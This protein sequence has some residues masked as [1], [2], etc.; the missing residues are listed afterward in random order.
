MLEEAAVSKEGEVPVHTSERRQVMREHSPGAACSKGVKHGVEQFTFGVK[1][2]TAGWLD[3]R[4]ERFDFSPLLIGQVCRI[5]PSLSGFV[6][7]I[8]YLNYYFLDTL[9]E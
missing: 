9:S 8:P 6:H 5:N 1:G 3:P 4:E 7:T 2:R